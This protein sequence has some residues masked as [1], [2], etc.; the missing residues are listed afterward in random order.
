MGT[1]RY[2]IDEILRLGSQVVGGDAE[3]IV[4]ASINNA[5]RRILTRINQEQRHREFSLTTIANSSPDTA[6]FS[7]SGLDDLTA[8]GTYTDSDRTVF[9]VTVDG[10][11]ATDTFKWDQDGGTETTGVSM[12]GAAQTLADGVT[13]TFA[14]TT[15]H[16]ENDVWTV[17]VSMKAKYGLPLYVK[18]DLNIEDPDDRVNLTEITAKRFDDLF[19]GRTESVD[20]RGYYPFGN[21]GVQRQPESTG[22]ISVVS[23]VAADET[24]R[25]V[26]VQY[27]DANGILTREKLTLD[28]TT[29]VTTTG[30]ADPDQGGVE[31]VIKTAS[32]GFTI[33]GNITIADSSSNVLARIPPWVDSPTYLWIEF[34]YIPSTEKTYTVRAMA[35]K[36]DLVN[37][38]DWPDFDEDY[39]RLLTYLGSAEALPLFGKKD[40][41]AM[42][43]AKGEQGLDEFATR[44]DPQPNVV[45][46]FANV[47]M[48]VEYRSFGQPIRGIDFGLGVAS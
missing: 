34:D 36:P 12:T 40:T 23:D 43:G 6:T 3:S 18:S 9:T 22:T 33:A 24:Y 45:L 26:T 30:S 42:N 17:I 20:P 21:I 5:Y 44:L 47:Q 10:T 14:A 48:G 29:A 38:D 31:R 19:P 27:Y 41:A 46:T 37:D 35:L 7:G 39:H 25:Y 16:T 8:G 1:Y 28:G 4:K 13:V 15:G 11:G 2:H 32:T